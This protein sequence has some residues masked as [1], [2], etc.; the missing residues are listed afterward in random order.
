MC[1]GLLR[2]GFVVYEPPVEERVIDKGLQHRHQ[3]VLVP[4]Q[5]VHRGLAGASI[6]SLDPSHFHCIDQHPK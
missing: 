3:R 5:H 6:R 4:S 2:F 1:L